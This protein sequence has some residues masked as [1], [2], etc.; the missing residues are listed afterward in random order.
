[1][2]CASSTGP[3]IAARPSST[4]IPEMLRPNLTSPPR[5]S[6]YS[7]AASASSADNPTLAQPTLAPFRSRRNPSWNTISARS[8]LTVVTSPFS[9]GSTI[10]FQKP[11]MAFSV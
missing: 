4:R 3:L 8:A 6:M 1:M 11:R 5:D 9:V 2:N 10:R 7:R